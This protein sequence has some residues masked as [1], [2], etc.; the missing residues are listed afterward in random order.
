MKRVILQ[1]TEPTPPLAPRHDIKCALLAL[2]F[3]FKAVFIIS[4]FGGVRVSLGDR[5]MEM[6][7]A[8]HAG[9]FNRQGDISVSSLIPKINEGK[10]CE[11]HR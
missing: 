8:S 2:P 1:L 3:G 6:K 9:S 11:I 4:K 7:A 5:N 10:M